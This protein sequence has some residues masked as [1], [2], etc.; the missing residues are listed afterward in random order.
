[1]NNVHLTASEK[2]YLW[3][4]YMVDSMAICCLTYFLEKC[5]DQ[6]IKEILS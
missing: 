4:N 3:T 2:F 5:E 6:E 1:M